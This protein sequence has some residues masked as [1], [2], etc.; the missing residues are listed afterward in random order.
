MTQE[1][2]DEA[3]EFLMNVFLIYVV[4]VLALIIFDGF[5]K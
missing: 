1:I 3:I 5:R 4:A 2:P